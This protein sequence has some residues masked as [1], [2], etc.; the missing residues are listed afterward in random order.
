[1]GV[2]LNINLDFNEQKEDSI[3]K[4]QRYI[5]II[6]SPIFNTKH[7][8][9]I[10]N[11]IILPKI[12]YPMQ[13]IEYD[14][15]TLE[16]IDKIISRQLSKKS[17]MQSNLK[18]TSLQL[19]LKVKSSKQLFNT[20]FCNTFINH[21]LNKNSQYPKVSLIQRNKDLDP[22]DENKYNSIGTLKKIL[23]DNKLQIIP[24][25][26]KN[27]ETINY[28]PWFIDRQI[29]KLF[30]K[31]SDHNIWL[32]AAS[33]GSAKGDKVSTTINY[34]PYGIGQKQLIP[35]NNS[36]FNAEL[37]G[38]TTILAEAP[39]KNLL[40]ITDC[41]NTIDLK[42]ESNNYET[43]NLNKNKTSIQLD[44][45]LINHANFLVDKRRDKNFRIRIIWIPAHLNVSTTNRNKQIKRNNRIDELN[46]EFGTSLTQTMIKMN[47]I[48]DKSCSQSRH[49][50]KIENL[51]DD[52]Y[53]PEV[54]IV[55]EKKIAVNN[56]ITKIINETTKMNLLKHT[57]NATI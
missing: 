10:I 33:D 56:Q 43:H 17:S 8:V 31:D 2:T 36:S 47:Q 42:N 21:G 26:N 41:M 54:I 4:I 53:A 18:P 15:N 16:N 7:K 35:Y 9:E 19:W 25:S 11:K 46:K 29:H 13:F 55:N 30:I 24:K 5:S 28:R 20:N 22:F 40:I 38:I 23:S 3:N 14:K 45:P 12:T 37:L 44:Y 52:M 6:D 51:I 39:E 1:L 34:N 49:N 50:P 48:C 27:T 57:H 32:V